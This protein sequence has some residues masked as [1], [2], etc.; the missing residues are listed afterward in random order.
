MEVTVLDDSIEVPTHILA[1]YTT[2]DGASKGQISFHPAHSIV[3]VSQCAH[4]P[5][6]TSSPLHSS[7]VDSKTL[8][9]PILPMCLPN[10]RTF[11]LLLRYLYA[12]RRS[13]ILSALL[14][15][16][17]HNLSVDEAS[18]K[19]VSACNAPTLLSLISSVYGLWSNVAALGI[20]E[21]S[22][23]EVLDFL[24]E[25]LLAALESKTKPKEVL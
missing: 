8:V 19:L 16:P 15:L 9:L 24:W 17:T 5:P 14:P 25:A 23:W 2:P 10:L 22:L 6:V 18:L 1:V 11:P 12:H 13:E 3:L 21:K 7:S 4:V 20:S